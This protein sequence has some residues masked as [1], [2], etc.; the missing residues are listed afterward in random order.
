MVAEQVPVDTEPATSSPRFTAY[1]YGE[2]YPQGAELCWEFTVLA[3]RVFVC[4]RPHDHVEEDHR[5]HRAEAHGFIRMHR[6]PHVT[7]SSIA[8]SLEDDL[9]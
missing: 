4:V 2:D 1:R 9:P 7:F 8:R 3:D 5:L 6:D